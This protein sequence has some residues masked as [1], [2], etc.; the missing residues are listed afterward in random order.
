MSARSELEQSIEKERGVRLA[1]QHVI[2]SGET[3]EE[4]VI[5]DEVE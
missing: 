5:K 1:K 2:E 3:L 4:G